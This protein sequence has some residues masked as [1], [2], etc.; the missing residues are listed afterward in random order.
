MPQAWTKEGHLKARA[1]TLPRAK[2]RGGVDDR[3]GARSSVGVIESSWP[4]AGR[5]FELRALSDRGGL[6]HQVTS[7]RAG[8]IGVKHPHLSRSLRSRACPPPRRRFAT[9]G[10][11]VS[12]ARWEPSVVGELCPLDSSAR[13]VCI[14]VKHPLRLA[15]FAREPPP[16]NR[17]AIQGRSLVVLAIEIR[18]GAFARTQSTGRQLSVRPTPPL[19]AEP[20]RARCR[21]KRGGGVVLRREA[22]AAIAR[23]V[24]ALLALRVRASPPVKDGPTVDGDQ[25]PERGVGL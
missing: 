7:P 4:V 5:S 25:P 1:T 13:D 17:M 12:L 11:G 8:S 24:R 16:L 21:A 20:F 3:A 22:Q 19:N 14:G 9:C 23:E 6:C 2:R 15:R 10:G 18:R